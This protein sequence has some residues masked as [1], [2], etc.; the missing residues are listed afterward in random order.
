ML[1]TEVSNWGKVKDELKV[2]LLV[3]G[4]TALYVITAVPKRLKILLNHSQVH[5][6]E[7]MGN[8][9]EEWYGGAQ[10]EG[11]RVKYK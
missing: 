7:H 10:W 11:E 4:H 6:I 2:V 8:K 1:H 5:D 3:T 9:G